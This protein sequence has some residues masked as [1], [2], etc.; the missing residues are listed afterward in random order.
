MRK[1]TIGALLI[2]TSFAQAQ[3][4]EAASVKPAAPP[5]GMIPMP[6][7]NPG[8][9]RYPYINMKYLLVAAYDVKVFQV[10]GPAWLDTERF[11]I[12]A[13]MAPETTPE[14]FRMMLQNL[15]AE[16]FKMVVHRESKYL[17]TYELVVARNGPR[18]KES[19]PLRNNDAR[20]PPGLPIAVSMTNG[21]AGMDGQFNTMSELAELLTTFMDRPV[22]DRTGLNAK[23]DFTLTYAPEGSPSTTEPDIFAAVETQ[24]GLKLEPKKGPVEMIVVDRAEK[25]PSGN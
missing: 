9:V 3:T 19:V 22:F 11:E 8:R 21:R 13:T 4:F 5:K 25:T 23:Y 10:A 20:R 18:F 12:D 17:P 15:L 6:G 16:R 1:A 2:F 7:R 24:L 14:Q